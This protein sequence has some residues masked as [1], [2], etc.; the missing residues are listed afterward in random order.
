MSSTWGLLLL[1]YTTVAVALQAEKDEA[2]TDKLSY[3]HLENGI[4]DRSVAGMNRESHISC[5]GVKWRVVF[6]CGNKIII[7]QIS[8]VKTSLTR[9]I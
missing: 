2:T 9:D 1:A 6:I 3:D 4:L 5:L 8:A 7:L